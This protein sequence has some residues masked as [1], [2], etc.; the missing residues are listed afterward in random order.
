MKSLSRVWLLATPWTAAYQVPPS[1]GFSRQEYWS[2]VPL[3]SLLYNLW[4]HKKLDTAE[5]LSP[6]SSL[7]W[8]GRLLC[9]IWSLQH[10]GY[11]LLIS[12]LLSLITVLIGIVEIACRHVCVLDYRKRKSVEKFTY[13][14]LMFKPRSDMLFPS[15]HMQPQPYKRRA[16]WLAWHKVG[17]S[18]WVQ[19]R[20]KKC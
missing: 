2:G 8:I 20:K 7:E 11:S 19:I 17:K 16:K 3:P 15:T 5:G 13:G 1:M 4:D 10:F 9:S 12:L 6:S 14:I 18:R